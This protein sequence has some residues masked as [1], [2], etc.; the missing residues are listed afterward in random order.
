[1][2]GPERL[3]R[4]SPHVTRVLLLGAFLVA[5]TAH[6][7]TS[8]GVVTTPLGENNG[9]RVGP[10][11]LHPYFDLEGRY[12]SAA[13]YLPVNPRDPATATS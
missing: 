3:R 8:G 1:M 9:I 4:M 7:Q 2:G 10:G 6:A 12:D 13:I 5:A 11:R